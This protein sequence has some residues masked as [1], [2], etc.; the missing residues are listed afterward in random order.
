MK[1]SFNFVRHLRRTVAVNATVIRILKVRLDAR[2]WLRFHPLLVET[3][4]G[5]TRERRMIVH[6]NREIKVFDVCLSPT[7][8][9]TKEFTSV[10]SCLCFSCLGGPFPSF[11]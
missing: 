9:K 6:G 7:V 2:C 3:L 8:K 11:I 10:L 4:V 1:C 5:E